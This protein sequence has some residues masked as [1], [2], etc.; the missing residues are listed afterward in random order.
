MVNLFNFFIVKT[1]SFNLVK[2]L[3]TILI[4]FLETINNFKS[5]S[6]AL[7]HWTQ[8]KTRQKLLVRFFSMS[9]CP[10]S[11]RIER[12]KCQW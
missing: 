4:T 12:M 5:I 9:P 3:S 2:K 10:A 1:W 8:A 11:E 7:T 6:I